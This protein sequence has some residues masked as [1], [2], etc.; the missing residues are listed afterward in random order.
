MFMYCRCFIKDDL[1][2]AINYTPV[3]LFSCVSKIVE[4]IIFKHLYNHK[5]SSPFI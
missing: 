5:L 4:I 2:V 1:S 3:S